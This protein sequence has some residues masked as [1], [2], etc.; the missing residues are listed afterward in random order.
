MASISVSRYFM[1]F[2][3]LN[4]YLE[5]VA[6]EPYMSFSFKNFGKDSKEFESQIALY[7]DAKFSNDSIQISGSQISS[8]GRVIFKKPVKF[9]EGNPR[10]MVS[11]SMYFVFSMSSENGD[12]LA[13]IIAPVNFPWNV[14]DGC[15]MGLV[16]DKKLRFL[17][18]EFDTFK[19]EKYGDVNGN[20]VGVDIDSPVS[21]KVSNVSSINLVLNSAEKLQAW[22]DYEANSKRIEL[23]LS[24]IG[25]VRPVDPLLSYPIDLSQM[26]ENED[27]LVGLSSSSG[28]SSQKSNVHS[29]SFRSRTVP[30][31]MH[32]EPMDP[33][34]FVDKEEELNVRKR[35]DCV[36]R[37][38]A[39]LIFGTGCGALGA[40]TVLFVWTILAN[41]RPVVPEEY[42]VRPKEYA[43]QPKEFQYKKFNV[44]V[45][46]AIEDGK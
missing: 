38:L 5:V 34:S 31:W 1:A 24:K 37:I 32:S 35:S 17:A 39:A 33:E 29:W 8:S 10:N 16:G 14:F 2:F 27:V 23:R 15:S 3:L 44:A 25:V 43:L 12:G 22:I 20:H 11:F 21:A 18:V 45:D 41:R 13:F 28:N 7:G 46:K 19:D 36:V 30:H 42:V 9:V 40:F 4:L 26:W 6:A